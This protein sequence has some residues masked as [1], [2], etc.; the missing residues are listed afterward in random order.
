VSRLAESLEVITALWSGEP[1]AFAG[2]HFRLDCPGQSPVPLGAIP[3]VIGG[4][5]PR[6]LGLVGRHADWWNLPVDR[7]DQLDR[8]RPQV[9]DARLSVQQMVAFV[10]DG[11]RRAE[12][13]ATAA[14]RFGTMGGGLVMGEAA[15][16]VD[17]FGALQAQGVERCYVWF[18]DFAPVETLESFGA[19]VIAAT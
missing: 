17:H 10:G 18:T 12:I 9:G 19:E 5:G 13:E 6:M 2:E 16:L 1:V 7:L 14:R 4:T 11:R 15:R 3:I 8:L